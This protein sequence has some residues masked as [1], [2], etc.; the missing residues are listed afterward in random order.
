M[1]GADWESAQIIS[2]ASYEGEIIPERDKY[3]E[4]LF[5]GTLFSYLSVG[6][7]N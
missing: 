6:I 1:A 5:Q 3:S 7:S 4:K 2:D